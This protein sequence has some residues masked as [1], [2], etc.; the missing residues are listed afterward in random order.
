[1]ANIAK[2]DR[3]PMNALFT[4]ELT[5][6]TGSKTAGEKDLDAFKD[7]EEYMEVLSSVLADDKK[8]GPDPNGDFFE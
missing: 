6:M 4:Q 8:E 1:M 2:Q 5:R 7:H 3:E